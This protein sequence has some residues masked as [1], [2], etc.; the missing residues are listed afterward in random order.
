MCLQLLL[1]FRQ[2]IQLDFGQQQ[3]VPSFLRNPIPTP[4]KNLLLLATP[5]SQTCCLPHKL[6]GSVLLAR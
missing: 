2:M 4:A 5:T 6:I 1:A 3:L